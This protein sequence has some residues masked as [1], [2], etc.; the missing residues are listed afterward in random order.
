MSLLY[1]KTT[2][3]VVTTL[4]VSVIECRATEVATTP[5]PSWMKIDTRLLH[6]IIYVSNLALCSYE[7]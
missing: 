3:C 4:V 5:I 6:G 7:C 1:S 2:M